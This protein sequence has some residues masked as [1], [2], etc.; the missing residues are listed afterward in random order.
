MFSIYPTVIDA[1]QWS[2]ERPLVLHISLTFEEPGK[3]IGEES[4][5]V[6]GIKYSE[7]AYPGEVGEVP[8]G[9]KYFVLHDL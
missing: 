7:L 5:A 6:I 3:I 2:H 1:D 4:S 9:Q 8:M